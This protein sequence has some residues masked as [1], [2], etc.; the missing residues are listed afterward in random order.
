MKVAV[1]GGGYAGMA[2]AVTLAEAGAAV[3]VFEAA[4]Q[5][6]GRARCVTVN[7]VALD[8]G[9]HILIGAYRETLRL[10]QLVRPE[11]SQALARLPLDWRIHRRFGLTAPPLP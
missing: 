10:V 6:G 2:A 3:S 9:L 7:G 8:N 4:P 5:L 1:I 11:P